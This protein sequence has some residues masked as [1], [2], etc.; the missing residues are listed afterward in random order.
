MLTDERFHSNEDIIE[1]VEL[2][3]PTQFLEAISTVS[4]QSEDVQMEIM[5]VNYHDP[6]PVH[7]Q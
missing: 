7:C 4:L 5:K 6:S 3:L 2:Q 1:K